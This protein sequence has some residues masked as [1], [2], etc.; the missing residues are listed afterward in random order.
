MAR[1]VAFAGAGIDLRTG[2]PSDEAIRGAVR[3]IL[4]E[5]SFRERAT[6][7]GDELA[8]R[9]APAESAALIERLIRTVDRCSAARP[10][11]RA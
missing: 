1:R 10:W 7:I 11:P 4:D 6:M 8:V 5:P 9:D 3:R 2:H